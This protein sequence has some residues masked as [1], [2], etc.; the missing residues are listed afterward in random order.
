MNRYSTLETPALKKVYDHMLDF[1]RNA[2]PAQKGRVAGFKE[3]RAIRRELGRRGV[4]LVPSLF[5]RSG[6]GRAK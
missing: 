3:V 2:H 5:E 1:W 6:G 4:D